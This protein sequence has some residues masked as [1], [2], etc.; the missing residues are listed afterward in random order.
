MGTSR[1]PT[2]NNSTACDDNINE[3]RSASHPVSQ[4]GIMLCP[5][6][7]ARLPLSKR[8]VAQTTGICAWKQ[9]LTH[10]GKHRP[11]PHDEND[12]RELV[13]GKVEDGLQVELQ[14]GAAERVD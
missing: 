1:L 13:L 11:N 5:P 7:N 6:Y 10:L 2:S 14:K 12:L 9:D 8:N 4:Y 3:H